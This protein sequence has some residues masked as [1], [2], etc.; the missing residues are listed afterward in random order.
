MSIWRIV[1][2]VGLL[3]LSAAIWVLWPVYGFY[4]H[5]GKISLPPFG[6][7]KMQHEAPV[8]Q[9]ALDSA[10][11]VAGDKVIALLDER[12]AAIGAP[13]FSAAVSING[14]IV[15]R[16]AVGWA[17]LKSKTPATPD[18]QFR[19]GSTSKAVTATALA[20]MVDKGTID[21]DAPI[22]TYMRDIPN[23]AWEKITPR[24][25]ASHMAGL[26]HYKENGD[27][28]GCEFNGSSQHFSLIGN[29]R[30]GDDTS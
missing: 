12:R 1:R 16:G 10:F 28:M 4:A 6:W 17:D 18:T 14:Q 29:W 19:I 26:P 7:E 20:R 21:L 15:W 3:F 30:V 24:Q 25:L 11:K 5:M 13:A 27:L 8:T 23:P 22:S 2:L 9:E